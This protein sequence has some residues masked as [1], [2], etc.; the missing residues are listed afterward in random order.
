MNRTAGRVKKVP[1]SIYIVC[2]DEQI[3]KLWK[4]KYSG[5]LNSI[6]DHSNRDELLVMISCMPRGTMKFCS[7]EEIRVTSGELTF[8]KSY[9]LDKV[10]SEVFKYAPLLIHTWLAK[11]INKLMAHSYVLSGKKFCCLNFCNFL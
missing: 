1:Q 4:E 6:D 10:P 5:V 8:Y 2:G 9:G 11:F 3:S 7:P